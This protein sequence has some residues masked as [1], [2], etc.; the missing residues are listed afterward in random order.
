MKAEVRKLKKMYLSISILSP[1]D[2]V[3]MTEFLTHRA[4]KKMNWVYV[5]FL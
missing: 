5:S 3:A 2:P 4:K 1:M